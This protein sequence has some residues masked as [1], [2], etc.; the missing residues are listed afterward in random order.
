[1]GVLRDQHGEIVQLPVI[2]RDWVVEQVKKIKYCGYYE[3]RDE[4]FYEY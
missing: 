4:V 2:S 3:D 1:M